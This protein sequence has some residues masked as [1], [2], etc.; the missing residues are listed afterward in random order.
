MV[1]KSTYMVFF[2][3]KYFPSA[4]YTMIGVVFR[5]FDK[6]TPFRFFIFHNT[7]YKNILQRINFLKCNL[8][9][10]SKQMFRIIYNDEVPDG[11]LLRVF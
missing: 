7:V 2:S 11:F 5:Q 6:Y 9:F 3:K 1:Y 4:I 10:N 8:Q